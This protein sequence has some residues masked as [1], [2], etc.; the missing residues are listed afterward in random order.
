MSS[1]VK[2]FDATHNTVIAVYPEIGVVVTK[3]SIILV[4]VHRTSQIYNPQT[5]SVLE[6]NSMYKADSEDGRNLERVEKEAETM[7]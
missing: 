1:R 2:H 7:H 4:G 5:L 3:R 6:L